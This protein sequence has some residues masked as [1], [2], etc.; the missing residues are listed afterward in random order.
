MVVRK[1]PEVKGAALAFVTSTIQNWVPIFHDAAVAEIAV[2]TLR[3]NLEH[4][5]ASAV[6]Y[7]IM[8]S[9]VHLLLGLP[10]VE[11]LSKFMQTYKI[12]TAKRVKLLPF[13]A[14]YAVFW[15]AGRFSLWQPR[16]DDLIVTSERQL[17][18]KLEYIHNNPVKAG[19]VA[20]PAGWKYSSAADWMELGDGP[21]PIDK[22]FSYLG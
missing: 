15:Q 4:F 1:R 2:R 20:D 10:R 8:P 22:S 12:L 7:V 3:D 16:F 5:R 9:H 14:Q 18:V 6:G 21:I 19:L 17:R 13:A 11:I